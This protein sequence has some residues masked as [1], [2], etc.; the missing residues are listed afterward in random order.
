MA[1]ETDV[2][3]E[4]AEPFGTHSLFGVNPSE[5]MEPSYSIEDEEAGVNEELTPVVVGPPGYA[6]PDA[7]TQ[8]GIL[9]PVEEHPL[10]ADISEDYGADERAAYD[11]DAFETT[12]TPEEGLQQLSA[13]RMS[14]APEDREEWSKANWQD[15]AR[16]HGLK[17]G[18]TAQDVRERV[19]A[20]E[21]ELEADKTMNAADWIDEIDR[22]DD[23]DELA[24]IKTRYD[25]SG[26]DYATVAAALEKADAEFAD[27][28]EQKQ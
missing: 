14:G 22:A 24:S 23:E 2:S 28:S 6:S 4:D 18:G 10:S 27:N 13:N 15:A 17:V 3:R 9:V 1:P 11:T 12:L 5:R 7:R 21:E 25:A 16:S 20:Y 26:S 8:Q 19:E